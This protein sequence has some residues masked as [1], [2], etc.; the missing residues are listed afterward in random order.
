[1]DEIAYSNTMLESKCAKKLCKSKMVSSQKMHF[2]TLNVKNS[3]TGKLQGTAFTIT[4][5]LSKEFMKKILLKRS[6]HLKFMEEM[7]QLH[8]E[9]AF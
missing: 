7:R 9:R 1:M 3:G 5:A 2:V 8:R 6:K 4:N